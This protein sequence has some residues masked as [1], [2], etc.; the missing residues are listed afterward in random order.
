MLGT[1]CSNCILPLVFQQ[2]KMPTADVTFRRNTTNALSAGVIHQCLNDLLNQDELIKSL[3]TTNF[4]DSYS[5][6]KMS[7]FHGK[8]NHLTSLKTLGTLVAVYLIKTGNGSELVLPVLIEAVWNGVQSAM[9]NEPWLHDV[10]PD[11]MSLI[12]LIPQEPSLI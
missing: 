4:A 7:S 6:I 9:A 10:D 3:L 12:D 5:T 11:T 2:L 1:G 8:N